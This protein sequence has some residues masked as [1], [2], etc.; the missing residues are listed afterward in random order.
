MVDEL[1]KSNIDDD[2]IK[3]KFIKNK[4]KKIGSTVQPFKRN[5]YTN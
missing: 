3:K 2:E 5:R 1:R 4:K